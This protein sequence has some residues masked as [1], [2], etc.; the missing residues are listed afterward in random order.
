[1]KEKNDWSL[2]VM[3]LAINPSHSKKDLH[4]DDVFAT[5]F[6]LFALPERNCFFRK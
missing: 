5:V 3:G 1:M 2:L 6:L 4:E